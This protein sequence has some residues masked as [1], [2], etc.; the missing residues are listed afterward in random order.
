MLPLRWYS[1]SPGRSSALSKA[2]TCGAPGPAMPLR[3]EF[4][5]P[6]ARK[7]FLTQRTQTDTDLTLQNDLDPIH[8]DKKKLA[9]IEKE[10][11][12]KRTSASPTHPPIHTQTQTHTR[13]VKF[14]ISGEVER[15]YNEWFSCPFNLSW[16]FATKLQSR[17]PPTS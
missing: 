3:C 11:C 2:N 4:R 9:A 1:Y 15:A 5:H 13:M 17:V 14:S 12:N 16:S 6:I 8:H 10:Q 7:D